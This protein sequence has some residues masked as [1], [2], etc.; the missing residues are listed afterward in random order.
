MGSLD[1][2]IDHAVSSQTAV[3][4][5]GTSGKAVR[6]HPLCPL[7]SSEIKIATGMI[8]GLYPEGTNFMFKR[9]NLLEP[10]KD[11]LA[12]YLDAEFAGKSTKPIE[13]KALVN[14]YIKNTVGSQ[15]LKII[16]STHTM[17]RIDFTKQS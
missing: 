11:E 14:Y 1:E 10:P 4:A 2:G 17:P 7:T 16:A 15:I 8:K 12:P 9:L 13:R 5:N 3:S 6:Q